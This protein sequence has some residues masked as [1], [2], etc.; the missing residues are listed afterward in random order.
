MGG[1]LEDGGDRRVT[2]EKGSRKCTMLEEGMGMEEVQ[3]MVTEI[4][5]NNLKIVVQ[6]EVQL[7]DD[8]ASRGD[9]DVRIFLKGN[10]EHEY[11]YVGN[12]DGSKRRAQKVIT[13]REGRTWNCDHGTVCGRSGRDRDD[14]VEKARKGAG[15]KKWASVHETDGCIGDHPQTR[16]RLGREIIELSDDNKISM[17]SKDVGNDDVAAEGGEEGSKGRGLMKGV[18]IATPCGHSRVCKCK[19]TTVS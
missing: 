6:F 14:M 5:G 13:S 3:R 16:L 12:S 11:L 7:G 15:V 9:A 19:A 17:A 8:N 1:E 10:D 2:Y 18:L 4:I